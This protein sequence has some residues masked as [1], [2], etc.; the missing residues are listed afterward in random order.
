MAH[1]LLRLRC[2]SKISAVFWLGV[3]GHVRALELGVMSPKRK[4]AT[5]RRTPNQVPAKINDRLTIKNGSHWQKD[6]IS[7]SKGVRRL[8]LD[9]CVSFLAGGCPDSL[10]HQRFI[11]IFD[12]KTQVLTRFYGFIVDMKPGHHSC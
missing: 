6:K 5:H 10:Q 7:R 4:A 11:L 1:Q 8:R 3:R 12:R 9:P 2:S